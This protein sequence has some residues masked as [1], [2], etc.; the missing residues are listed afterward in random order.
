MD[1]AVRMRGSSAN[2]SLPRLGWIVLMILFD[3]VC[4]GLSVRNFALPGRG[5]YLVSYYLSDD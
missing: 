2:R 5:G 3:F 1:L 4:D